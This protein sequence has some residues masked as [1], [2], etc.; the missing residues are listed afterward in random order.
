MATRIK[1][2]E[3]AFPSVSAITDNTLT[4][5]TQITLYLPESSKVFK[6]VVLYASIEGNGTAAGN[7]TSRTLQGRLAAAAYT[8]NANANLY[9]GSGE[10]I[11]LFHA[12]D[13]TAH[14]T[15]NWTTET[16][17]TMDC[18]ILVDGT[19]TTPSWTNANANVRITY[20]Y[21]D[22]SVTQIK[23]VRIPL[24][25]PATTLSTTKPGTALATIPA[26]NT[27][28][29]EASK[30]YRNMFVT[31]QG[32]LQVNGATTDNTLS[33][34]LDNTTTR[35]TGNYEGVSA[36][37]KWFRY[38]WEVDAVLTPTASMGFY[39]WASVARMN[40]LQAW[41]TVTY[42]FSAT[43][44]NDVF[45]SLMLPVLPGDPM[46]GT[47]TADAQRYESAFYIEEPTAITTK[48]VAFYAFWE[49]AA[50]I[51][52]LNFKLGTGTAFTAYT[53]AAAVLCGSNGCMIRNDSAFTLA[54]GKNTLNCDVYR[55]DAADYGWTMDGF[56]IV[57]YTA[58]KPPNGY[59]AANTTVFDNLGLVFGGAAAGTFVTTSAA[60]ITI[61]ATDYYYQGFG[62]RHEY[63]SNTTGQP[64]GLSIGMERVA[65][66][67]G[68][69]R[70]RD[71]F[72]GT[73]HTDPETGLRTI[74]AAIPGFFREWENDTASGKLALETA[75]R[76]RINYGGTLT[77]FPYLDLF[78]TVHANT[79]TVTGTVSGSA[80]G[81]VNLTLHR[82]SDGAVLGTTSRTG[83]GTYSFTWFDSTEDVFVEAIEGTTYLGRSGNGKAS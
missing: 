21:D 71:I 4:T 38:I 23:T 24:N 26:L 78:F 66:E 82:A 64:I 54:R 1:T 56:F 34:Q 33:L 63:I 36:S 13:L 15:A 72:S 68:G 17:K 8:A 28:L 12:V 27:E 39:A 52:T 65:A 9:T 55:T 31:I 67:P 37:D 70:W 43:A 80:G 7:I 14:F 2:V 29:P 5:F 81:T 41:L 61:T 51:S 62:I 25:M 19:Q 16:S 83:N 22:T 76:F 48:Q 79:F 46:G 75:R 32:N 3:F 11:H 44:S 53:D 20:E 57:N 77:V 74:Y 60:P 45:V 73:T 50:A 69:L 35:T 58:A 47:T 42:E 18:Q 30:T 6:S 59:G 49:Q 40:H 10:D